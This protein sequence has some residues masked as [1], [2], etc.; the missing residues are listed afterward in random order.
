MKSF[1]LPHEGYEVFFLR[2][3]KDEASVDDA[4][5]TVVVADP[6]AFDSRMSRDTKL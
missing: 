6:F 4:G 2:F 1:E 3:P 5:E